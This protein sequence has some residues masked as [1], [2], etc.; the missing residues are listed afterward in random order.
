VRLHRLLAE[1][2]PLA[3]HQREHQAGDAGV[4][5]HDR[6]ARVVLGYDVGD[7]VGEAEQPGREAALAQSREEATAPD[8][9]CEREVGDRDPDRQEDQPGREPHPVGDRT[10]DQ[11]SRDHRER[12]LECDVHIALR[13]DALE[14]ERGERVGEEAGD[15]GPGV[16]HR[17]AP[18]DVHDADDRQGDVRH[19][20]HVEHGL[21]AAHAAVEQCQ[22]GHR[23]HQDERG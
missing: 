16:R 6:A 21:R 17:P 1:P 14:T 7:S 3:D 11:R 20:H 19:H 23:H 4:D 18:Q 12:E 13:A 9:V 8:H 5:V 2:E 22:R 10:T 15:V